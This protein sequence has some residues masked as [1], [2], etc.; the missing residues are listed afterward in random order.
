MNRD[1][2]TPDPHLDPSRLDA[3]RALTRRHFFGRVGSGVGIAAI[4]SM[5]G[6]SPANAMSRVLRGEPSDGTAPSSPLSPR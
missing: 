4:A 1:R 6:E 2:P 5:L 3:A